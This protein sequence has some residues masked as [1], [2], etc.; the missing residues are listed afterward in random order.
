M[1]SSTIRVA[2]VLIAVIT[3]VAFMPVLGYG[4]ADAKTSAKYRLV[5]SVTCQV[6]NAD[7]GKWENSSQEVIKYNKKGDPVRTLDYY[8]S[9]GKK[10]SKSTFTETY[11]YTYKKGVRKTRTDKMTR[12]GDRAGKMR[13]D[14]NGYPKSWS[15][16]D[17]NGESSKSTYVFSKKGYL[18]SETVTF[19]DDAGED[20]VIKWKYST[21]LKKG[22]PKKI[23]AYL[24]EDSGKKVRM[25]TFTFNKRGLITKANS[26]SGDKETF[27]YTMKNGRVRTV[28]YDYTADSDMSNKVRY[29]FTYTKKKT[30]KKRY[31]KMINWYVT[32]EG[33]LFA[34]Y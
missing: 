31:A 33:E 21:T 14:K 30:D 8:Y 17:I 12:G 29:K 10:E 18:K 16:V 5:K 20:S 15:G 23:V 1:R 28:V 13:Y 24:V 9:N 2:A 11:K 4:Q 22:L 34:W 7:T 27:N 6:Y 19:N 3:A 32:T 26:S 25:N